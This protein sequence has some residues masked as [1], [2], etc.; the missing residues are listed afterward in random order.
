MKTGFQGETYCRVDNPEKRHFK[1]EKN[2]KVNWEVLLVSS[3]PVAPGS[4]SALGAR[5]LP[6][7]DLCIP[8][9]SSGESLR[10]S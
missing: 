3:L 9:A 2:S 7:Q 8:S 6:L 5:P 4:G 10:M 1:E